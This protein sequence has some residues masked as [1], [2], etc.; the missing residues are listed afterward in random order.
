LGLFQT[1][2]EVGDGSFPLNTN[3]LKVLPG[4]NLQTILDAFA[5]LGFAH[6]PDSGGTM[7]KNMQEFK[8]KANG[9]LNEK[10][11]EPE[12]FIELLSDRVDLFVSY[13]KR[14]PLLE[15]ELEKYSSLS[16]P[17][18]DIQAGPERVAEIL[19]KFLQADAAKT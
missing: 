6:E 10:L 11:Q 12:I 1:N 4:N 18:T 5:Q 7:F 13:K 8:Y 2:L 14:N 9:R 17:N 15:P 16:I 19:T 3:I